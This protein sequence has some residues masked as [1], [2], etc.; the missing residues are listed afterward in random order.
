MALYSYSG[1]SSTQPNKYGCWYKF[2]CRYVLELPSRPGHPLI[3]GKACHSVIEAAIKSRNQDTI[4][5]LALAVA[6]ANDLDEEEVLECVGISTVHKAIREGGNVEEYFQFP[7]EDIPYAHE[8]RGYIDYYQVDHNGV[9]ITDWKTNQKSYTPLDTYQL[10]LYAAF[11]R[12]QYNKPVIGRLVFLRF[13]Q[14]EEHAFSDAEINEALDW[15]RETAYECETRKDQVEMG[16]DPLEI[17][18][19]SAGDICEYCDYKHYCLA[20]TQEIPEAITSLDDA[21]KTLQGIAETEEQLKIHKD[22]LKKFIETNGPVQT[23]QHL[24]EINVIEYMK[25]DLKA[26]KAVVAEMQRQNLDIGSI[27]KIGSDAQ[28]DLKNKHGWT[29]KT[30]LDLGAIKGRTSRLFIT[31]R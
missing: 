24:A 6:G 30:F 16:A 25:F 1:L 5:I 11:M 2:Y 28:K 3:F 31:R 12:R 4:P 19:K 20:S 13:N 8:I 17:F 15:A 27:L 26:R 21:Q 14:V 18:P 9:I 22:R 29:E 7:L 23:E 10:P